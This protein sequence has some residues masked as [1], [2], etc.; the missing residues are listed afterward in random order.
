MSDLIK[1]FC[2]PVFLQQ[3]IPKALPNEIDMTQRP[4]PDATPNSKLLHYIRPIVSVLVIHGCN[5][6]LLKHRVWFAYFISAYLLQ[7]Q[8]L[9]LGF[10]S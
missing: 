10:L 2:L 9:I 1:Y 7:D 8:K 6:G 4:A 5:V 3:G